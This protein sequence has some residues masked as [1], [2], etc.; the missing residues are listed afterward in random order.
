MNV[1]SDVRLGLYIEMPDPDLRWVLRRAALDRRITTRQLV[2]DILRDWLH[3]AGYAVGQAA[4]R[5][6]R[7]R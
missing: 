7:E 4:M 1:Q 5:A 6:E 3:A 2:A